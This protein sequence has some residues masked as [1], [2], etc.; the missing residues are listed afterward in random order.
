MPTIDYKSVDAPKTFPAKIQLKVPIGTT[1]F[2]VSLGKDGRVDF[3]LNFGFN[4]RSP[5]YREVLFM[6]DGEKHLAFNCLQR[7]TI[8]LNGKTISVFMTK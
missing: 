7:G 8:E 4:V 1:A 3:S 6:E 5:E 2:L